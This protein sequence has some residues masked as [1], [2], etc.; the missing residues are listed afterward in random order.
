MLDT[1]TASYII[2]RRSNVVHRLVAVPMASLY[3]SS[4]TVG[5]RMSGLARRPEATVLN[6]TVKELLRRVEALPWEEA[7]ARRYGALRSE[8]ERQGTG[9][10]QHDVLIAAHALAVGAVLATNDWAFSRVPRLQIEDWTVPQERVLV[11]A[12]W[13]HLC[14]GPINAAKRAASARLRS[15]PDAAPGTGGAPAARRG[16]RH[17][18]RWRTRGRRWQS[19]RGCAPAPGSRAT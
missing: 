10:S 13:P 1:N 19:R 12:R 6:E 2:R 15:A 4:I 16:A 5:V 7:T 8:L 11:F 18:R 14:R 3:L 17:P 9:L